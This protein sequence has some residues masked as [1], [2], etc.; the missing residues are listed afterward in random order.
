MCAMLSKEMAATF[1]PIVMW[2][3]W[4]LR[5]K[6]R[7]H[8]YGLI[9][10]TF[11]IYFILRYA[12]LGQ[13]IPIGS[14]P[15]GDLPQKLLNILVIFP[16]YIVKQFVPFGI[17]AF[18]YFQPV[19]SLLDSRLLLSMGA[20]ALFVIAAYWQRLNRAALFLFGFSLISLLP[21][22]NIKGLGGE[23]LFADRYLYIPSLAAC[24]L[25]PILM[26]AILA[27]QP[28][29]LPVRGN[30]AL[31]V[32]VA[33][34]LLV[35]GT[36]LVRAS[37][38]WKDA[39]TLYRESLK[40]SPRSIIPANLLAQYYFN[41][42]DFEQAEPLF[43]RIIE[44]SKNTSARNKNRLSS[45]YVGLGGIELSRNN[46]KLAMEFFSEANRINPHN[47]AVLQNLGSVYLM[48]GDP[49]AASKYFLE[50]LEANPRNE[51]VYNNLAVLNLEL[52]HFEKALS[53]AQKAVEI[54]PKFG[55]AYIN[56]AQAYAAL[57]M[58]D[59]A[60]EAYKTAIEVDPIQKPLAEKALADLETAS[61]DE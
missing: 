2:A 12:A 38:M 8:R 16:T 57:G 40:K 56:M 24:L 19:E 29:R 37:F 18:H 7:W 27:L 23:N 58:K 47:A 15:S 30:K 32:L 25:I 28:I 34:V 43:R 17:N 48:L 22:L 10:G 55:K 3:D 49:A 4:S 46:P 5:R 9:L 26:K 31:Y 41:R 59:R 11:A 20:M 21:L 14:G 35:Y 13:M 33:A 54:F 36:M 6:F 61:L 39:P 60:K 42:N 51:I 44:L 50:S 45:A 52:G 1:L 53:N